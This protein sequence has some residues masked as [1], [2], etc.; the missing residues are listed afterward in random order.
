MK[1]RFVVSLSL[2]CACA[3]LAAHA[4]P[5]KVAILGAPNDPAW[6]NDVQNKLVATGL[7]SGVDVFNI[8]NGN[9]LPSL[10]TL[11][12]YNSVLV[13]TDGAFGGQDSTTL[14]NE[15]DAYVR[16]GGGVVDAVFANASIAV[17][18]AYQSNNDYSILPTS[19]SGGTN[20]TLVPVNP[21]SPLLN[22]VTSF[23][24]GGSSFQST[25]A[26]NPNSTLVANWSNGAPLVA[27][28]MLGS[29]AEVSLNFFPPSSDAR[30]DFWLSST[31]GGLLMGN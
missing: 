16:G 3:S 25:G 7:F 23:D 31:N 22:G 20:L 27:Y 8:S 2:L 1:T 15:L 13:Y 19:Q 5:P 18:G 12:T 10:A 6:N 30:N 24:G 14:E 9:P 26:L 29:G 17:G 28:Q 11:Q 21:S 4:A